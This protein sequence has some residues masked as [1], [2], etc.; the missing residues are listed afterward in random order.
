MGTLVF[1]ATLGGAVNIIGPNIATTFSLT[2]PSVDGT[3]GQTWTTNGSGVLSFA[4][5]GTGGGGTGLT[6]FT[7]GSLIYASSSSALA[8]SAVLAANALIIGGG[9]GVA[10]SSITTGTGVVTAL[11]VNTGSAGAF[12]VNGGALGTPSSGT[13]TNL[14]GLPLTTG[15]TGT[16]P[17]ANG[18]TNLTSFTSGGVVYASSTSALAT[19]SALYF[20][21]TN[22]GVG[23]T[24]PFAG[25]ITNARGSGVQASI[26][27]AG[28]GT[29]AG[30]TSLSLI[31]ASDSI[32]YIYNRA[33]T[34]MIF[35]TNNT[36][37]AR[38]DASGNVMVG[39]STAIY[40]TSG[41]GTFNVNGTTEAVISLSA[42]G[43]TATSAYLLYDGTN[44]TF[45]TVSNGY[46]RFGTNN[47][48]RARIDS[49][50]NL[51]VG[52]TSQLYGNAGNIQSFGTANFVAGGN[53][54]SGTCTAL[55]LVNNNSGATVGT[56]TYT[57]LGTSYTGVNG[58]TFTASQ[59]ASADANTLDD[60]EEGTWTPTAVGGTTAGTTTYAV[61]SG[62]YTKIGNLVTVHFTIEYTATTGTG[63][64]LI[65]G[66][67]FACGFLTTGNIIT[68]FYNWTGGTYL[69][70]YFPA[71][72]STI[73]IYG[74][75]D[76]NPWTVQ[77]ITNEAAVF[78]GSITYQ[79]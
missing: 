79:V 2:L 14:T 41:R 25:S 51:L 47:A 17:T 1:Q 33:N 22:L 68:N 3:S 36:E 29:T 54:G 61:Q 71:S 13:A 12:V 39:L 53:A 57:N 19:G 21:G 24:S 18:G 26:E 46:T 10:P 62:R 69:S 8:S 66:L 38:I 48:E 75:T 50:G 45:Q 76:D 4:T 58:I 11:G 16:L 30:T 44:T 77:T 52:T 7:S 65:G 20:S 72:S 70:L 32:A 23:T 59:A 64:L 43:T 67:P 27:I 42:G 78:T 9:V 55:R 60:Y 15:V 28:N 40:N 5:L 37:R 56:V 63:S 35:G 74:G 49:S 34:A 6:S 31:Q 73:N